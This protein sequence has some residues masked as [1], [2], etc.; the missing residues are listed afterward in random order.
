MSV[1][2]CVNQKWS[3]ELPLQ[4]SSHFSDGRAGDADSCIQEIF[5][6]RT[7]EG[8]KQV[9]WKYK[10]RTQKL[11]A[12]SGKSS[13]KKSEMNMDVESDGFGRDGKV[14]WNFRRKS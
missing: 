7:M 4:E 13:G 14:K 9:W 11:K 12:L 8:L 6:W 10:Y 2:L 3:L 1:H 5:P